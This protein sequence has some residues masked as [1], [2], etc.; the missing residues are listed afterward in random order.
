MN[1]QN[2]LVQYSRQI[3]QKLTMDQEED[4][5]HLTTWFESSLCASRGYGKT[6]L[7]V[8]IETFMA[9]RGWRVCHIFKTTKQAEQWFVWMEYFGWKTTA[10]VASRGRFKIDLR[11]YMQGRGPRYDLIVN[12]EVGTVILPLEMKQFRACQHMLSGSKLGI[13][14]WIGT[15][16]PNSIWVNAPHQ[17]LRPYDETIMPW[18]KRAYERALKRDPGWSVD[19]EFRCMATPAGGLIL[20]HIFIQQHERTSVQYAIDS[21]P[22]VGYFVVGTFQLDWEIYVC[23]AHCFATL[24]ELADFIYNHKKYPIRLELNGVG[25]V[26]AKYLEECMLREYVE[27]IWVDD[28]FKYDQVVFVAAQQIFC[29]PEFEETLVATLKKQIWGEDKKPVKFSD[30]HWFDAFYLSCTIPQSWFFGSRT[31]TTVPQI[32]SPHIRELLRHKGKL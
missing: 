13:A 23:E 12:D 9:E 14:I 30:A 27:G 1:L 6:M 11:L 29:L 25:S 2:N 7:A 17:K 15:Q 5:R 19:Q 8:L 26:V 22:E 16:D 3:F 20:Q 21:N 31:A 18:V 4:L 10:W 28:K 24:R 32:S